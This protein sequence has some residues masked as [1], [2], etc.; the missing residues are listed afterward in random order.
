MV[1]KSAKMAP[2]GSGSIE[3]KVSGEETGGAMSVL[4]QTL[5]PGGATS[6]HIHHNCEE[7]LYPLTGKPTVT[8]GDKTMELGLGETAVIPRGV[9]HAIANRSDKEIAF[10]FIVT[11][12][13][14]E[15]FFEKSAVNRHEDPAVEAGRVKSL[16]KDYGVEVIA[17][18]AVS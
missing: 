4:R 12:G 11:P 13:G 16:A 6:T 1:N 9:P 7:T 15:G 8:I 3:L 5:P 18:P 17:P 10:L 14:I 2:T